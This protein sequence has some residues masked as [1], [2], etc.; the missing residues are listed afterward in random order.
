ME[1][2]SIVTGCYNEEENL[3][4]LYKQLMEVVNGFEGKYTY[5]IIIADNNSS[6]RSPQILRELAMKNKNVV[7][8]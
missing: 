4:E 8:R 3:P 7:I 2:I 5:E 1:K 6:D